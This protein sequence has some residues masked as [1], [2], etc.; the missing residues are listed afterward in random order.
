MTREQYLK[1]VACTEVKRI[2]AEKLAQEADAASKSVSIPTSPDTPSFDT[3][4]LKKQIKDTV[5]GLPWPLIETLTETADKV[6][7][8]DRKSDKNHHHV[9]LKT[10]SDRYT[11]LQESR[12]LLKD[13]KIGI[14]SDENM[15]YI[16]QA[17]HASV[18]TYKYT[19]GV[20]IYLHTVS[21][22]R[23]KSCR[24]T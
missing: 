6:S 19:E 14:N 11:V 13:L 8:K 22:V 5:D 15:V 10:E 4:K 24:K 9:V 23:K 2:Y 3:E 21:P 12:K 1:E 20:N 7:R 17:L 18:H 16:P